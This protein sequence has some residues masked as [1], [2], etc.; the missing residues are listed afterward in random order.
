MAGGPLGSGVETFSA[1]D[2]A[3]AGRIAGKVGHAGQFGD[4]GGLAEGA[5]LAQGGVPDLLGQGPERAADRLG[6]AY[7]PG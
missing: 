4:L 5:V 1:D 6:M 2:D 7:P 3:G